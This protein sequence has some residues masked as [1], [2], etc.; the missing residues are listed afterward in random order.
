M[1]ALFEKIIAITMITTRILWMIISIAAL[2]FGWIFL[3]NTEAFI[4]KSLTTAKDSLMATQD[5]LTNAKDIVLAVDETLANTNQA[6]SALQDILQNNAIPAAEFIDKGM[7]TLDK[8]TFWDG[9]NNYEQ[10]AP[11]V[12]QINDN[13][14]TIDGAIAKVKGEKIPGIS[15]VLGKYQTA[16]SENLALIQDTQDNLSTNF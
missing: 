2:V 14:T 10:L 8:A 15:L 1:R 11:S 7:T 9:Q 16:I 12:S 5:S 6:I 13:L 4:S 3:N